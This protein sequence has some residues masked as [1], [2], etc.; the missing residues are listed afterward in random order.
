LCK[1]KV[2]YSW[3]KLL[4]DILRAPFVLAIFYQIANAKSESAHLRKNMVPRAA[5]FLRCG[6]PR[7]IRPLGAFSWFVLWRVP[8]NEHQKP[9]QRTRGA[10]CAS[11]VADSKKS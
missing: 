1:H 3:Q 6:N 2:R 7:G 11:G 4:H 9:V 8:K 5:P 10:V